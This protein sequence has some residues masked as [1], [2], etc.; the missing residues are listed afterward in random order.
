MLD[1]TRPTATRLAVGMGQIKVGKSEDLLTAVLGSCVG[2]IIYDR[3]TK[4]SA[5]A[6]IVLPQCNGKEGLP[7]KFADSAIDE[8]M[9]LL[10]KEHAN[11]QKF[12]AKIA[13]GSNMFGNTGPLQVGLKNTEAVERKL[14]DLKI[15]LTGKHCGGTKGRR[16]TFDCDALK[17]CIEI[18]GQQPEY[19]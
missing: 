1:T 18:V 2:V 17:F 16:V 9:K 19:I 7:G 6:H 5:M 4:L 13:G 10:V 11:P 8:L 12:S 15:P 3:S 14:S